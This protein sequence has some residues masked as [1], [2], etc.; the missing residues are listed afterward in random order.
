M[1][2][3]DDIHTSSVD[4]DAYT[5]TGCMAWVIVCEV[6]DLHGN[7]GLI[8]SGYLKFGV[9]DLVK[10]VSLVPFDSYLYLY[11]KALLEHLQ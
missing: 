6:L 9:I 2:K 11:S 5:H 8:P 4:D 3:C 1:G 10:A 7:R